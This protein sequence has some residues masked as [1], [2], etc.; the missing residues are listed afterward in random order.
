MTDRSRRRD[1]KSNYKETHPEAG[2]YALRNNQTGKVLIGSTLNLASMRNKLAFARSTNSPGA[3]DL[4]LRHEI[5]I[6]GVDAF[7]LDILESIR[8]SP[9]QSDAEIRQELETLE[10]LHRDEID[11]ALRY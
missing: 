6:Y 5:E 4:R 8:P 11:P 1:L 10:A 2:V 3:L 9:E 7:E